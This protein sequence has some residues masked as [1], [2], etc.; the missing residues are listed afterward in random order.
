MLHAIETHYKGYRFRSRLEA[1]W[2]VFFDA[3][4]VQYEYE[5]EGYDLDGVWY[6]PDFWLP[7][8]QCWVEIKGDEMSPDEEEKASRLARAT[9]ARVYL[10]P[11][12]LKFEEDGEIMPH[13]WMFEAGI[14]TINAPGYCWCECPVCHELGIHWA[15][16]DTGDGSLMHPKC[17]ASHVYKF[18]RG[19]TP[20]KIFEHMD[21]TPRLFAA[22]KAARSARFEHGETP[23]P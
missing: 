5:K 6:L 3:L 11:G 1:R 7:E 20:P 12:G 2:A 15:D 23:V 9:N 22:Y 8:Q 16:P 17:L 13:A 21:A 14:G 18:P 10:F 4:G 19:V